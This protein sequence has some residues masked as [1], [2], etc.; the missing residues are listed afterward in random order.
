ML[1]SEKSFGIILTSVFL[2]LL[3]MELGVAQPSQLSFKITQPVQC[4]LGEDCYIRQYVNVGQ[5]GELVDYKGGFLTSMNQT[6]TDFALQTYE[7]MTK[8]VAVLAP[9]SGTVTAIKSNMYDY[10]EGAKSIPQKAK[11]VG[12][13]NYCGNYI[14]ID[15]GEGWKS[16]LCHLRQHSILV[17]PGQTVNKSQMIGLVGCSGKTNAPYILFQLFHNEK[18]VDPF[19]NELWEPPIPYQTTGVI[20][21]GI[22]STISNLKT[23]QKVASNQ[24]SL[25]PLDPYM[26]AWIRLYGVQAGDVQRFIFIQPD[27]LIYSKP[28]MD[29][30]Q[31][32]YKEWFSY[33]GYPVDKSF[34][35]SL[36]GKWTVLYEIAHPTE[37]QIKNQEIPWKTIAT[38]NFEMKLDKGTSKI[39]PIVN[40]INKKIN[41]ANNNY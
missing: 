10:Y 9:A 25:T 28:I 41:R 8:G 23:V 33:G 2:T 21:K 6:G 11:I 15:H 17:A 22:I 38:F 27:G 5:N 26:I 13:K 20:D 31:K 3:K 36:L 32:N 35:N 29:T 16:Q 12:T 40:P 37:E 4:I 7:Q 14:T 39:D 34:S 19:Q 18:A 24:K 30:I 1:F